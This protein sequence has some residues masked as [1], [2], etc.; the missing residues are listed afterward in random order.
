MNKYRDNPPSSILGVEVIEIIDYNKG[1][2][3]CI[4][5]KQSLPVSQPKSNV[6]QFILAD[7]SKISLRPSGTE[8]KIKFYI[9]ILSQITNNLQTIKSPE[10]MQ[11]KN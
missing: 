4:Q 5:S 10:I 8:P 3:Y 6:L 9:S 1:V 2:R 11:S 7:Q